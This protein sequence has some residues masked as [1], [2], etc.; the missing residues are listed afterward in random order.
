M[1]GY[2]AKLLLLP[3]RSKSISS[4]V[5]GHIRSSPSRL[6]D[7]HATSLL[8]RNLYEPDRQGI[9][10]AH[11]APRVPLTPM[12]CGSQPIPLPTTATLATHPYPPPPS[13]LPYLSGKRKASSP[14]PERGIT[15][16]PNPGEKPD[17]SNLDTHTHSYTHTAPSLLWSP[18]TT[19]I[20]S[21][22]HTHISTKGEEENK[23]KV[24]LL[25]PFIYPSAGVGWGDTRSQSNREK[26]LVEFGF[27][28]YQR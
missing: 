16:L 25:L 4:H 23:E 13:G 9:V 28:V 6:S 2:E 12:L 11:S 7:V 27:Q 1:D 14:L 26:T 19:E 10:S 8:T 22:T 18:P 3:L 21:L 24:W 17:E 15:T 20:S 5:H